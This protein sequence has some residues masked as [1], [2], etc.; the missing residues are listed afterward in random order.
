MG[1]EASADRSIS[2]ASPAIRLRASSIECNVSKPIDAFIDKSAH[3][4]RQQV[5]M[6]IGDMH[7]NRVWL[8]LFQHV[9]ELAVF[10]ERRDLIGQ[11]RTETQTAETGVQRAVD[12]VAGDHAGDRDRDSP[13][14]DPEMPFAA[15]RQSAVSDAAVSSYVIRHLW[16][17]LCEQVLLGRAHDTAYLADRYCDERGVLEVCDTNRDIDTFLDRIDDAIG[18]SQIN[19]QAGMA[20]Q[21]VVD[22][23][24]DIAP[25]KQDRS[26]DREIA[27]Q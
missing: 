23:R 27:P 21:K 15:R 4:V 8:E 25:A 10:A 13:P 5:R 3:P 16:K 20:A 6:G 12:I 2:A 19:R 26:R 18:Q 24:G 22:D 11:K 14:A 9:L 1:R 7:G 17:A